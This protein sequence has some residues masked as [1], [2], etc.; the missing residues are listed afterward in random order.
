S[1][2]RVWAAPNEQKNG[3]NAGAVFVRFG[4]GARTMPCLPLAL[5]AIMAVG[6]FAGFVYGKRFVNGAMCVVFLCLGTFPITNILS[7]VMEL[8]KIKISSIATI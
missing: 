2:R 5:T 4:Q 3:K 1:V 6:G 8:F 7:A